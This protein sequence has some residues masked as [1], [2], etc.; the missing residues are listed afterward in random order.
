MDRHGVT[1]D[2]ERR[3]VVIFVEESAERLD[4]SRCPVAIV[5]T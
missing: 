3:F 1:S 5:E 4:T 2:F